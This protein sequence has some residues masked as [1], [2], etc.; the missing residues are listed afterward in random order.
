M[1]RRWLFPF[2]V[3]S[4][5]VQIV[6]ICLLTYLNSRCLAIQK[7]V[8]NGPLP[9]L[10][11]TELL[12]LS[13]DHPI[14]FKEFDSK[15]A[16]QKLAN[17]PFFHTVDVKKLRPSTVSVQYRLREPCAK[18][19]ERSNTVLDKEGIL[20]PLLPYFSPR[21]LP[22][23]VVGEPGEGSIG[24]EKL[25]LF[26]DLL[27][28]FPPYSVERVDLA[29]L[30]SHTLGKRQIVVICTH[31]EKRCTLRLSSDRYP[32]EIT[33]FFHI[34]L[35]SLCKEESCLIDLRLPRMACL[36]SQKRDNEKKD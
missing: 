11:L 36:F 19:G 7:V 21:R 31:Q 12:D 2:L 32:Q 9:T 24:Q 20:F 33:D 25:T 14:A 18:L 23:L 26:L 16:T 22:E 35:N 29:A 34:Q 1:G 4:A 8:Q 13:V 28:R 30:E 17:Y 15:K 5:F 10:L 6:A 27:A 3:F